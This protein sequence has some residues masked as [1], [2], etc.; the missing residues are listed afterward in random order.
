[1]PGDSAALPLKRDGD[2]LSCTQPS[3]TTGEHSSRPGQHLMRRPFR[4][5]P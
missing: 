2:L 4:G 1:V 5:A 3:P